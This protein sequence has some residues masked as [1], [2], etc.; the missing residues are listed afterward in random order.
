MPSIGFIL[1]DVRRQVL[2]LGAGFGGLELAT[3]LSADASHEIDVVL[4]DQ[5]DAFTFGFSKLDIFTGRRS[6]QQVRLP[7]ARIAL[8]N[9]EFRQETVTSIDPRTRQVTTSGGTYEPDVLV[10]ALGADYVP[11]ATPGFVDDGH[12]FYS[13]AGAE[14]LS[15]VLPDV[16]GG[17]IVIAVLGVPFKC[18]PAPY[19]GALLLHEY[20]VDRGVRDAV[21]IEVVTPMPAPIPPS[22]QASAAIEGALRERHIGYTP[23]RRVRALDP[24]AHIAL[25]KDGDL[26][27][28]LFIGVPVHK[29]PDVVLASG[30]TDGGSDGWIAVDRRNLRTRF[31]NVYAIGD[32]ADAPVPR[33]GVFAEA[34]AQVV[35]QDIIANLRSA[36]PPNPFPGKGI[37][38][39]E[40]GGGVAGKVDVDFLS[41]P[42][43]VAPFYGPSESIAEEKLEFADSR[44]N[45]WFVSAT[46]D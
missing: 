42:V 2:V 40:F 15:Q 26:P 21:R 34:E 35:A 31:D 7:Y 27:Y 6:A 5:N 3:R 28:D 14:R 43:P 38:Y 39:I 4:I 36:T 20:L 23:A 9:V 33:A 1:D 30:L 13:V 24:L 16:T 29:V 10:V 19:E 44:R 46:D 32:C 41:G 25:T 18:P 22:P 17:R 37:C 12:E 45:R 8:P 11:E